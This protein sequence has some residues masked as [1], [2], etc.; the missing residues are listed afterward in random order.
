MLTAIFTN[1]PAS[2]GERIC[3]DSAPFSTRIL[4]RK[5]VT[6]IAC[7]LLLTCTLAIRGTAQSESGSAGVEG[8]VS[9]PE[10][11]PVAGATVKIRN[12]DTGYSR[13][14]I[15]DA[16]GRYTA[17]VMPVGNYRVEGVAEGFAA[18]RHEGI[19]LTVGTR[20]TVNISLRPPTA[21]EGVIVSANPATI[22][23][24]EMATST[25]IGSRWIGDLPIRGRNFPEFVKL[26]PG[27][28]Q[29]SDRFGLVISGQRSINSN[30]SIDGTDF[31]DPLQGNQRGGN[32]SVFFFPQAAVREFQVIRS[33]VTAEVGR[34]NAGFVNVVT[35]S[36]TND[37]HGEAFYLNRNAALTSDNAFG[38]SLDTKQNQF[39]GA[40][41]GPI[42]R[43]RIFFFGSAEQNLLKVPL[44]V[45]FK[46]QAAGTVV[47]ADLAALQGQFSG[48]NNPTS[49]FVRSDITLSNRD[50]LNVF[51]TYSRLTGENFNQELSAD[52]AETGN[53]NRLGQSHGVKVAFTSVFNPNLLNEARAQCAMD[54]REEQPS[55]RS[56]QIV[57]AGFGTI[58]GD[59]GR[60][61]L[62]DAHRTQFTDNVSVNR[63][64][65][66]WRFGF[67]FNRNEVLQ[68][69][70]N[71]IQGRYDFASLTDYINR[72]VD[73][74]RQALPGGDGID[75]LQLMGAQREMAFYVQDKIA[76]HR[77]LTLTAGVRWDG[78]WNPQPKHP[79]Q[80]FVETT[81][82]PGDLA[83]WQPRLGLA[84]NVAG[85]G[86]TIVRLSAGLYDA[87]TPANLLQRVSTE[88]GLSQAL[89]DSK[90]DKT[91]LGLVHFPD[92][93]TS[94]PAGIKFA[95]PSIVG[96]DQSFRNP[97]SFQVAGTVERLIG[98]DTIVSAGYTHNSTWNL[99]RR[100]DRNLFPAKVDAT[101]M[102]IFPKDRPNTKITRFAINESSAHSRYDGLAL[103]VSRRMSKRFQLQASYTLARALDD[104]SNERAF[105]RE[106]ALNPFDL[107]LER[108]YSKQD[109]RNTFS[110]TGLTD[111]PWGFTFSTIVLTHSGFPY[112]AIVGFDT[113]GDGNDVNDRAIVNGHVVG[114]NSLR[115]P[116]FFNLDMRVMKSVRMRERLKLDFFA[117]AFNVTATENKFFGADSVS[118]FGSLAKPTATAGQPLF[119]PSTNRFGGPR[120]LQLGV[121]FAF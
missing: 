61:R 18:T 10:G 12:L 67:D 58:G 5:V 99:Q 4:A 106:A 6:T 41:G 47:P 97:R 66:Q 70:V 2:L 109:V 27:V 90:A 71:L 80:T 74:Y 68:Q 26:T 25:S 105:N 96:W 59:P 24:E 116:A 55:V 23:R 19:Q 65:H 3:I 36:G 45:Q 62:F 102:P 7:A 103:N 75:D 22:E 95:P 92:V 115:E 110:M 33:G 46:P 100:L 52:F 40:F 120:Q 54:D 11:K 50:S 53:Y 72:K 21:T 15:S 82:I 32:D 31:N 89:V 30:V 88:N 69:R 8:V 34:T 9:D 78:Q 56:P 93:L 94:I 76:L 38:R 29:E 112:T 85:S 83:Q 1:Q 118:E 60:P 49:A 73:R 20:Q 14:V 79:N 17:A 86:K 117:E 39:G 108:S 119:A 42:K 48:S 98:R 104:D 84:W 35:K 101:G 57:I 16:N 107:S 121:R 63:G 113:Q 44:F 64:S 114:R 13:T 111:L 43:D 81:N 91:V 87:R 28:I 77:T 51:Y 37:F